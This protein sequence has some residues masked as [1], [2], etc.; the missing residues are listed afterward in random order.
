M[1]SDAL[2]DKE[3]ILKKTA[4]RR[5]VGAVT[6]VILMLIVLP[7]VLKDRVADLAQEDVNITV[8][9]EASTDTALPS[10]S[11]IESNPVAS[12]ET[13]SV[14]EPTRATQ[15]DEASTSAD[16]PNETSKKAAT[17]QPNVAAQPIAEA[18]T[19]R[20]D[21]QTNR[22]NTQTNKAPQASDTAPVAATAEPVIK[23]EIK[24]EPK[25]NTAVA[26]SPASIVANP[27]AAPVSKKTNEPKDETG[28]AEVKNAEL[29]R[30]T[31]AGAKHA[32][33]QA[34]TKVSQDEK[35]KQALA[36]KQAKL[37]EH[38]ATVQK[39]TEHPS[40]KFFVQFGVF[41][42]PNNLDSLRQ[43]LAQAGIESVVEP[44]SGSQQTFKLRSQIY[45]QRSDAQTAQQQMSALGVNGIV[46]GK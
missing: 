23:A 19:N 27:I 16:T 46:V 21:T 6:L 1:A 10:A 18:Q 7:F 9:N 14:T 36:K 41:S 40:G 13:V 37:I 12:D 11:T 2:T 30:P 5:L 34:D 22:T 32:Q 44:V 15:A 26:M 35:D 24:P 28:K 43:K 33:S 4:R 45:S 29:N 42:D 25:P 39:S 17:E 38:K 3:L 20:T 31:L 8:V